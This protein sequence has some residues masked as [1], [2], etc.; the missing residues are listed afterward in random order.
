MDLDKYAQAFE[1]NRDIVRCSASHTGGEH[2]LFSETL[3]ELILKYISVKIIFL[4]KK[5][6][7][8]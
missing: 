5:M 4:I 7:S 1:K 8:A 2:T 6:F 3:F